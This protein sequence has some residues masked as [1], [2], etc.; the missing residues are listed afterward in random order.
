M[1][2]II[3]FY[4]LMI[5][6][7]IIL[8][9]AEAHAKRASTCVEPSRAKDGDHGAPGYLE[10]GKN[11]SNGEKV[12]THKMVV[13]EGMEVIALMAMGDMEGTEEMQTKTAYASG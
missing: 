4:M 8:A 5:G 10:D 6:A 12:I 2:I 1:R 11:G 3:F 13:M 7:F 9:S